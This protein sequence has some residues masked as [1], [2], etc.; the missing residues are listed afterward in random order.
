MTEQSEIETA[1]TGTVHYLRTGPRDKP[2][3]MLLPSLGL[4]RNFWDQQITALGRDY[5]VLAIDVLDQTLPRPAGF[6]PTFDGLAAAA[7]AVLQHAQAG[8]A[9]VVGLSVGSMIAQTLALAQPTLVRSLTLIGAAAAFP[10]TGREALRERARLTREQGMAAV[11]PLHLSRWF[12]PDFASRRPDIIERVTETLLA[13]DPKVH[14]ALWDMVSGL[15]TAPRLPVLT[16][17]TLVVVGA[18][19]TSTPPAAARLIADAIAGAQLEVVQGASHL[20]PLEAPEA[21]NALLVEFLSAADK[22]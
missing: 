18:E 7:A 8:P 3:I 1:E 17:P 13:D 19:D 2:P 16:C 20:T 21:V 22:S 9:H 14:A 15:D 12:T 6:Q 10:D 5:N 4:N 11:M